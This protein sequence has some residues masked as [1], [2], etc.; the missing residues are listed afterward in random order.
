ME[1]T[2]ELELRYDIKELFWL[3]LEDNLYFDD[4]DFGE[5]FNF[6]GG[7][8][9]DFLKIII[10]IEKKYK[11]D[12]MSVKNLIGE[13]MGAIVDIIWDKINEKM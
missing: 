2:D 5:P 4:V 11:L 13:P 9:K 8:D 12:L 6:L 3:K 10:T 7:S 1:K